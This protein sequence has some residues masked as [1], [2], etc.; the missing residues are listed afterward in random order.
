MSGGKGGREG[1]EGGEQVGTADT[2]PLGS[3]SDPW[4]LKQCVT[5][6]SVESCWN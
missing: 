4:I 5:G 3:L 6:S 1:G 2:S